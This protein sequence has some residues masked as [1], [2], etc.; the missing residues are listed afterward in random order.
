MH[1]PLE[2]AIEESTIREEYKRRAKGR[3]SKRQKQES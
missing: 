3:T 2:T 1:I